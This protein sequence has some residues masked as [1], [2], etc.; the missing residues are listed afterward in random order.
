[1]ATRKL[2]HVTGA[3]WTAYVEQTLAAA[4]VEA[5]KLPSGALRLRN[6]H[7]RITV[8]AIRHVDPQDLADLCGGERTF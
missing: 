4:G 6:G 3:A 8:A 7:T 5:E 1:M 2:R